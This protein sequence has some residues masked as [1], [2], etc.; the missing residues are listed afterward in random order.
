MSEEKLDAFL[1]KKEKKKK[2]R[3][4]TFSDDV[5]RVTKPPAQPIPPVQQD[6]PQQEEMGAVGGQTQK[7]APAELHS[8]KGTIHPVSNWSVD[9]VCSLISKLSTDEIA[10]TFKDEEI[11][12]EALLILDELNLQRMIPKT[13]PRLKLSKA[14]ANS[15]IELSNRELDASHQKSSSTSEKGGLYVFV[16]DSNIWIEGKKA[17]VKQKKLACDEDPRLRIEYGNFIDVLS[18]KERQMSSVIEIANMYGSIPPPNDSLWD[19]MKEK[20]WKVD[21]KERSKITGKEKAVDAQLMVDATSF[22]EQKKDTGGTIVLISGDKDFIPLINKVLEYPTW[23][24]EVWMWEHALSTSIKDLAKTRDRIMVESLDDHIESMTFTEYRFDWKQCH[25][26]T[27]NKQAYVLKGAMMSYVNST[28]VYAMEQT[29]PWPYQ[30]D[31]NWFRERGDLVVTFSPRNEEKF[32][33]RYFTKSINKV[34]RERQLNCNVTERSFDVITFHEYKQTLSPEEMKRTKKQKT[35]SSERCRYKFWCHHGLRCS[36]THSEREK[37]HFKKRKNHDPRYK[38]QLC[39]YIQ[40]HKFCY[41][42]DC[43]YAHGEDDA[44]CNK[45]YDKGHSEGNCQA[46]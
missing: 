3:F 26:S 12:G 2:R 14:L 42:T 1:K 39:R 15:L 38:T 27:L 4:K 45:C 36:S 28:W 23:N 40:T 8:E 34:K 7:E 37:E 43:R 22:A 44:I 30:Y 17:A 31:Y 29:F 20:G 5:E 11:D 21:L 25:P 24:V 19:K 32:S 9:E 35:V 41:N 16:D 10:E 13:G 6:D 46:M 33:D 18:S